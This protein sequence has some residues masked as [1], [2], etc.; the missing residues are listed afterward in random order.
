M[1][2][3]GFDLWDEFDHSVSYRYLPLETE[4]HEIRLLSI[5]RKIPNSDAAV[6]FTLRHASN[7]DVRRFTALSYCWGDP[8]YDH[9]IIVNGRSMQ[10]TESLATALMSIQSEDEEILLWADAIC[11]NQG[12]PIEKTTQVQLMRNIYKAASQVIIWLGP[13]NPGTHATMRGLQELGDQ[14]LHYGL[15]ELDSNDLLE[16][17]VENGMTARSCTKRV[18]LQLMSNHLAEARSGVFPFSWILSDFGKRNW[19]HASLRRV[20]TFTYADS[21]R[22]YGAFRNAQTPGSLFSVAAKMRSITRSELRVLMN[23]G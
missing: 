12:D 6:R 7:W 3:L 20:I 15:W 16:W 19:F 18:I 5:P 9:D 2:T 23:Q 21:D 10:I 11:I 1:A 4:Y 8:I 14:L 17:D 13:S 22:G